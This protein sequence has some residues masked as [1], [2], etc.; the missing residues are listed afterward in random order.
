MPINFEGLKSGF[1]RARVA[2]GMRHVH[3]HDL[4][5]SCAT[6]LLK[7]GADLL[8]ISKILGHSSVKMTEATPRGHGAS[9]NGDGR[10]HSVVKFCTASCT[11]KKNGPEGPS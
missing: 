6:I 3:F 2:A 10:R 1:A 7:S 8:T 11:S 5:H 4:R 9:E